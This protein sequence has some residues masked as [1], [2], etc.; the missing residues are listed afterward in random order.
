VIES[1]SIGYVV[2]KTAMVRKDCITKLGN[3]I[4]ILG[5]LSKKKNVV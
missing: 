5:K 3:E 4:E 1:I 2:V